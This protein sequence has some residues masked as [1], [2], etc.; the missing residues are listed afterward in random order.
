MRSASSQ[1]NM[2]V[3]GISIV[4]HNPDRLIFHTLLATL[5]LLALAYVIIL[6][7]MVFNIVERRALE[8]EAR[9]L[10][11]EVSDLELDYISRMSGVDLNFAYSLGYKEVKPRF[12]TRK[13]LGA[14]PNINLAKN[15]I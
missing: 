12:A 14:L 5:G 15:D 2:Q 7:N 4:H 6:G 9:A 8:E 1:I 10:A 11:S 13:S 3:R